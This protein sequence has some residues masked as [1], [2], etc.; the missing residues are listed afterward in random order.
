MLSEGRPGIDDRYS[1]QDGK[2]LVKRDSFQ[3]SA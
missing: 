2:L 3:N 1:L